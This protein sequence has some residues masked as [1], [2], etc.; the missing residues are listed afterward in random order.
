MFSTLSIEFFALTPT[1]FEFYN[2]MM[3][4]CLFFRITKKKKKKKK[5]QALQPRRAKGA[6]WLGKRL[7][8]NIN[9]SFLN[10]ISP[11]L[12][13]SSDPIV[14]MRLGGSRSRPYTSRKISRV[15]PGIE[16]G[17]FWMA[18]RDYEKVFKINTII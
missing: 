8:L 15:Q 7:S 13:S 3:K 2:D 12:V 10:R 1:D 4:K 16:S 14:L 5:N 9:F 17:T 6:L 18:V 11:L